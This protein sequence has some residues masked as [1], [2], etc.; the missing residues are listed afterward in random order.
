MS[1]HWRTSVQITALMPPYLHVF[2][3]NGRVE[4]DN[5]SDH[6]NGRRD[7]DANDAAQRN[8]RPVE[9]DG[10]VRRRREE[11]ANRASQLDGFGIETSKKV[12]VDGHEDLGGQDNDHHHGDRLHDVLRANLVDLRRHAQHRIGG[13]EAGNEGH[14]H[15]ED[16]QLPPADI[17]YPSF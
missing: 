9:N 4:G 3:Y 12:V 13:H 11:K 16:G 17:I 10:H 14:G 7:G 2:P 6:Q 15:G 8:G 1:M 5:Q